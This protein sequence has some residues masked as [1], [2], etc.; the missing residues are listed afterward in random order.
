[1]PKEE[2]KPLFKIGTLSIDPIAK[3]A[4]REAHIDAQELLRRHASGEWGDLPKD[5]KETQRQDLENCEAGKRPSALI[6]SIYKLKTGVRILVSTV[7]HCHNEHSLT[8]I[9]KYR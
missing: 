1:M 7:V 9:K 8:I 4:L 2:K 3:D 5:G 6:H